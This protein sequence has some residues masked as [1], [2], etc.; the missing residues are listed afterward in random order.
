MRQAS[1]TTSWS[2]DAKEWTGQMAVVCRSVASLR[3]RPCCASEIL[4]QEIFGRFVRLKSIRRDWARCALRDG[5]E[6]WLPAAALWDGGTY[7]PTHLV[8][9]R[10]ARLRTG[11]CAHIMLPMGSRLELGGSRR[12]RTHVALPGSNTGLIPP[13]AI[14][15]VDGLPWGLDW[16]DRILKEVMGTPYLWGGKSTFGFDCS[17]LVQFVFEFLGVNL[18][19]DSKDQARKGR[20]VRNLRSLRPLDLLFFGERSGIDHVAIHLGELAICH[21]SGHVRIESLDESSRLFRSDLLDGFRFA[22]RVIHV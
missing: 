9:K 12:K 17:G 10:F 14:L 19:R 8:V 15:P 1:G 13:G 3:S 4:T 22:R 11:G 7:E 20:L 18:P 16:V 2:A 21:A 5:Y 6:G